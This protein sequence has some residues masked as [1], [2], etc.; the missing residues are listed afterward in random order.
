MD[1]QETYQYVL[2]GKSAVFGAV[3]FLFHLNSIINNTVCCIY[4]S[5]L[6]TSFRKLFFIWPFTWKKLICKFLSRFN[7][8]PIVINTEVKNK[9][10]N[11]FMEKKPY[12]GLCFSAEIMKYSSEYFLV[13]RLD[14][15]VTWANSK[16][17]D[18]TAQMCSLIWVFAVWICPQ[19]LIVWNSSSKISFFQAYWF[20]RECSGV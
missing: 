15:N 17:P 1:K 7:A 2:V 6:S 9:Y 19:H 20:S 8:K 14:I 11:N 5:L 12:L 18:P 4:P 10:W 13:W 3:S 16:G